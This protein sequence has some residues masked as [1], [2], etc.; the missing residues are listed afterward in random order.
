M[1]TGKV[2]TIFNGKSITINAVIIGNGEIISPEQLISFAREN[3]LVYFDTGFRE[4]V[5]MFYEET[6]NLR[7]DFLVEALT[8][9]FVNE[10]G[11]RCTYK[12]K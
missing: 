5:S 8:T 4:R 7:E 9:Y 6:G 10:M 11:K 1:K 12:H 3:D 2:N